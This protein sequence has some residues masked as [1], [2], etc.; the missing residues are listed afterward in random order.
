MRRQIDQMVYKLYCKMGRFYLSS[1][2]YGKISLT[3]L[4]FKNIESYNCKLLNKL[5]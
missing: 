3:H 4:L 1:Q 2:K 5:K